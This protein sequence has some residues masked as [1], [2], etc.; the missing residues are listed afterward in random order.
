MF[1]TWASNDHPRPDCL[2][3]ISLQR[4]IRVAELFGRDR[5]NG[6]NAGKIRLESRDCCPALHERHD[7]A[8]HPEQQGAHKDN[9]S[10]SKMRPRWPVCLVTCWR[11]PSTCTRPDSFGEAYL[12]HTN[13]MEIRFPLKLIAA[14][15]LAKNHLHD[16]TGTNSRGVDK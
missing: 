16:A 13:E 1:S 12:C 15:A 8:A 10:R 11:T 4:G 2:R 14:N 5:H 7:A 3:P 6:Q 9:P